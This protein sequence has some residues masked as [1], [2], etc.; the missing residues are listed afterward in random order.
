VAATR[1]PAEFE[2][3]ARYFAP[4]A[5]GCAG[6]EG[7]TDD[8]AFID[9]DPAMEL[10]VTADALVAGVHF[11]AEDP[12]ALVARKALRVNLSDL[13]AKGARPLGYLL[14]IALPRDLDAAWVEAFCA[15]LAADQAEFGISLMGGDTTSTPGPLT[16]SITAFGTVPRGRAMKRRAARAGDAVVVS[17]T[18]GD[19]A[20]GLLALRGELADLSA[21]QRDALIDRYHLPRPRT[22]LGPRLAE[23]GLVHA[24]IDVSD[25]LVADLG[26]VCETSGL[27]AE[28]EAARVPLSAAATAAL[29]RAPAL[30]R[31]ILSGGDDYEILFTAPPENIDALNGLAAGLALKLTVIGRMTAG[32][33]VRVADESG[34]EISLESQGFR[35]F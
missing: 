23:S 5:R 20:L 33:E 18:I 34:G 11:R 3:I 12:P 25:G 27:G 2:L 21:A 6:A 8:A 15:G 28:I 19:A 7:L 17:G 14:T 4:L 16:L 13:A 32:S 30:R 31:K 29:G 24:A 9:V 1:L 10:V 35:H 26:H 22:I